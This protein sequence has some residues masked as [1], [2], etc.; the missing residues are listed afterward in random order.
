MT[1][2]IPERSAADVAAP[3]GSTDPALVEY[4]TQPGE[5]VELACPNCNSILDLVL[6]I[7]AIVEQAEAEIWDVG[8]TE[9]EV[10]LDPDEWV[11]A[12]AADEKI[13]GVRCDHCRWGYK[14]ERPLDRLVKRRP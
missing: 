13:I 11:P 10:E 5:A 9:P 2:P 3:S 12:Q 7:R 1:T 4:R 8:T 14:G 6:L